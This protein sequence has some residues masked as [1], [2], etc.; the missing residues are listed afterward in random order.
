MIVRGGRGNSRPIWCR[1]RRLRYHRRIEKLGNVRA[2]RKLN[3]KFSFVA[4]FVVVAGN[5]LPDFTGRY[6]DDRIEVAVVFSGAAEHFNAQDAFF[7]V[8]GT[9]AEGLLDQIPQEV[10]VPF[11]V[12]KRGAAENPLELSENETL[13]YVPR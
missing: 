6:P 13:L 2:Q 5:S 10:G 9:V 8:R 1:C 3:A 11:A 7:Q 4:R 12:A